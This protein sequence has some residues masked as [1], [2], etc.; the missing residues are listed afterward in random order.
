MK[1]WVYIITTKSM[2]DLVKIGF[3]TKDPDLRA[4]ELNNTGNPYHYKVEYEILVNEPRKLEQ[5]VHQLLKNKG[6]HENKEWFKCSLEIAISSIREAA[7]SEFLLENIRCKILA[8]SYDVLW[9]QDLIAWANENKISEVQ[10]SRDKQEILLMTELNLSGNQLSEIPIYIGKLANLTTLDLSDNQLTELPEYIGNLVYLLSL[11]LNNNNFEIIP[12]SIGNLTKLSELNLSGNKLTKVPQFIGNLTC[13]KR[14]ALAHNQI[15]DLS[16]AMGNL[17]NL[18]WL[19]LSSNQLREI[20]KFIGSLKKLT[21]LGLN[22]NLFT[23][24]PEV[25]SDLTNLR[26]ISGSEWRPDK[27]IDLENII[28]PIKN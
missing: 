17:T 27:L 15:M 23:E 21:L 22:D 1:G 8:Q 14:L 20:P 7:D 25:L 10:L 2:P 16:D 24:V 12:E 9:L 4:T 6:L 3:S 26:I 11:N 5:S 13:L 28:I 19:S 18:Q